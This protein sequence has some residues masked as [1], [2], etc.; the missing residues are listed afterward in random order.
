MFKADSIVETATDS[1]LMPASIQLQ[2]RPPRLTAQ[3]LQLEIGNTL[4]ELLSSSTP[5][6][7]SGC[8]FV[9]QLLLALLLEVHGMW[10][11]LL[12]LAAPLLR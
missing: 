8:D 10:E 6:K 3:V 7:A 1:S 2:R 11:Q 9:L 4:S 5:G 12:T